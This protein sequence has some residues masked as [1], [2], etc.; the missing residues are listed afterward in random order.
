MSSK[1]I[2]DKLGRR[3][4]DVFKFMTSKLDKRTSSDIFL[5]TYTDSMNRQQ[6][7]YL[8]T[9]RGFNLYIFSING[10]DDFKLE[11]IDKFD[12]MEFYIRERN[13]TEWLE[14]RTN[15]KVI[16][17]QE[18]DAILFDMIPYAESSGS[19]NADK[20]FVH[21]SNLVN[22]I[23]GIEKGMRDKANRETLNYIATL[24]NMISK[25]IIEEINKDTHYKDIYTI[26]K[27]KCI[28]FKGI[29]TSPIV[30]F[31]ENEDLKL[32]EVIQ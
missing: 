24:E 25:T 30:K 31:I 10:H 26:C 9:K 18:T 23:T 7:E 14:T 17:R 13:S 27:E 5:N 11:Y 16:R 6:N 19:S 3:H 29:S 21:F 2:A 4:P 32:E 8:L 12:A 20:Y 15:G 22:K 1:I 28:L